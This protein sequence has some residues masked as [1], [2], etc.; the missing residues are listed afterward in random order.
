MLGS[1]NEIFVRDIFGYSYQLICGWRC[2]PHPAAEAVRLDD[3][4]LSE[5]FVYDLKISEQEWRRILY[6][7]DVDYPGSMPVRTIAGQFARNR[8]HLYQFPLL[9]RKPQA[10]NGRDSA[11]VFLP[12]PDSLPDK[13]FEEFGDENA[14]RALLQSLKA[15]DDFWHY[16]L[17]NNELD[18]TPSLP[19][20]PLLSVWWLV[21]TPANCGPI[22]FPTPLPNL[23]QNPWRL[24]KR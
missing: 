5:R 19:G 13:R 12:G 7:I 6:S 15:D 24:W 21:C 3:P 22:A 9:E 2:R 4:V 10:N 18:T 20:H 17:V 11:Y 23:R 8:L 16:V 1:G 14:V